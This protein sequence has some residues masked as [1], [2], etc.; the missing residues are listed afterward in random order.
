MISIFITSLFSP[1]TLDRVDA[2][3]CRKRKRNL[4]TKK[5]FTKKKASSARK[6]N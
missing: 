2:K 4:E 3:K 1:E 5:S 6:Q